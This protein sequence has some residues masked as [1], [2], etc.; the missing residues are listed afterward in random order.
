[1]NMLFVGDM[2]N[3]LER[4]MTKTKMLIPIH[5]QYIHNCQHVP[6]NHINL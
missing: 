1:M 2:H 4:K 5:I 6:G 3:L